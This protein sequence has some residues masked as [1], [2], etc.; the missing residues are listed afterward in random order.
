VRIK[1]IGCEAL[2]RTVY[3][4]AAVSP[5]IVDIELLKLGLHSNPA[6]LRRR[7][8]ERIDAA[9]PDEYDTAVLAYGL[10]GKAT[11]DLCA[12]RIPLVI[13]RAHDCITLFLGAR[14]R[15]Q[16][17][18]EACP[19]TYW[20]AADYIERGG[21]DTALSIGNASDEQA[22]AMRE[23]FV[24]TYGA[25]NADYLME[26]MGAWSQ[27][28]KRA[29][30]IRMGGDGEQS[31]EQTARDEAARRGWEFACIDGDGG[32]VRRLLAG[33]WDSDFLVLKPGERIAESYDD[34][35]VS[36]TAVDARPCP[37]SR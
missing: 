24:T 21:R 3:H 29:V 5:H 9:G 23:E 6:D 36:A 27:H 13:P 16:Q 12:G 22:R 17:E 33:R 15:Y 20:Y 11:A 18:F 28:Y 8:Q 25:E 32:I 4:A 14:Q 7:L 31:T 35:V 10:C 19:G 26:A 34:G 30:F 2:A 1:C 37:D